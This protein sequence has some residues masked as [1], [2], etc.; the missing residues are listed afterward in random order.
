MLLAGSASHGVEPMSEVSS[1]YKIFIFKIWILITKNGYRISKVRR[2][3]YVNLPLD[4][5]HSFIAFAI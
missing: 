4:K 2:A 1:T 3:R 5:A